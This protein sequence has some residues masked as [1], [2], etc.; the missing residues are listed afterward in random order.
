MLIPPAAVVS[1]GIIV[2]EGCTVFDIELVD[3]AVP[4]V[5]GPAADGLAQKLLTSLRH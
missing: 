3:V 2:P 5:E 4:P 1:V